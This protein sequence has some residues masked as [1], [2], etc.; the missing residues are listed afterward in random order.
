MQY[1]VQSSAVKG[2]RTE[3][4]QV[5]VTFP[6]GIEYTYDATDADAFATSVS[7]AIVNQDSIGRLVNRAI[8]SKELVLAN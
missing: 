4:N 1:N 7:E 3:G 5:F 8:Q 6:N 2:L